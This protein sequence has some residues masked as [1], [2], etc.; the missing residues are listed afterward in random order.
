MAKQNF[1]DFPSGARVAVREVK[2]VSNLRKVDKHG[3]VFE[4]KADAFSH[5]EEFYNTS[6]PTNPNLFT[7]CVSVRNE[8]LAQHAI[9]NQS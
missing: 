1:F 2:Y 5:I 7:H 8:F 3:W 4:V 6:D 9:L